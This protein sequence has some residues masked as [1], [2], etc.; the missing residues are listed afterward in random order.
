MTLALVLSSDG[1]DAPTLAEDLAAVGVQMIPVADIA[2]LTRNVIANAPDVVIVHENAPE[3]DLFES[4]ASLRSHAPRP[5]IVFT[6]DPDADKI[7]TAMKA[8]VHA[9]VVNGYQRTRLRSVIHLAEARFRQDEQLRKDLEQLNQRFAERKLVDR[10]RGILM[11]ARQLRE[12]EA[13]RALRRAAMHTKQRIGQV[14]QQVIDSARYAEAVNRAGQLRMLSQRLV[15]LYMLKCGGV[16]LNETTGLF[17]ASLQQVDDNLEVIGRIVSKATFGDL[18]DAVLMPWKTLRTVL[19]GPALIDRIREVNRL[20]E[21][22]L[23]RSEQLTANLEIAAFA[24]A[25]HVINVAGRQRMLS[26]RLAKA[27]LMGV[28]LKGKN[29]DP[30]RRELETAKAELVEGLSYLR[31]VPL[32]NAEIDRELDQ[33]ERSWRALQDALPCCNT[34]AGQD[35]I[36]LQSEILLDHFDRLTEHFERGLQALTV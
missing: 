20:A 19:A 3:S 5:V 16:R 22:V 12:D 32:S 8:G 7:A 35:S 24:A 23:L 26:Q 18:L 17:A 13:Y 27:A 15:K 29:A 14:S 9:Y 25:L 34:A 30:M 4:I 2:Q 36:A 31:K 10:A 21:D 33:A 28:L 11:G 1:P 6:I